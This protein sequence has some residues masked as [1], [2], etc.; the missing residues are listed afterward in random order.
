MAMIAAALAQDQAL[1]RTN[2]AGGTLRRDRFIEH[3]IGAKFKSLLYRGL[4][5]DQSKGNAALVGLSLAHGTENVGTLFGVVAVDQQRVIL[6]A[7]ERV[8][9][10]VGRERKLDVDVGCIQ[11]TAERTLDFTVAGEEESLE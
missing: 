11:N 1:R 3:E 7:V 5:V 6:L 8:A 4:A 10:V 9:S 2:A